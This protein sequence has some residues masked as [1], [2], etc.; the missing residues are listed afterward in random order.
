M[1]HEG[2]YDLKVSAGRW[3]TLMV[4][5]FIGSFWL[6]ICFRLVIIIIISIIISFPIIILINITILIAVS[7]SSVTGAVT[8]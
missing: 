7:V 1:Y 3:P 2:Y 4:L 5:I 8:V 6:S